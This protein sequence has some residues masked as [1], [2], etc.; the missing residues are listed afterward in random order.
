[1]IDVVVAGAGPGGLSAAL[2]LGRVGRHVLVLDGGPWRNV[3]SDTI[4]SFFTQDGATPA[5]LKASALA[6]LRRYP[7]VKIQHSFAN[8]AKGEPG[9]FEVAL[10]NGSRVQARGLLLATGVEDVLPDIPGLQERWGQSVV[11]CPYCHGWERIGLPLAVLA[12]DD[13]WAVPLAI[14]VRRF[15]DDV[16]LCTNGTVILTDE[17]RAQL[18]A[19][20]VAIRDEPIARLEGSRTSLE[21]MVFIN[22]DP[23][24]RAALF[25]H[26]PTRQRSDLAAE[27]G[28]RLLPNGAVE[29]NDMGQT[30]QPGI[31]A[32]GDMAQTPTNPFPAQQVAVAVGTGV[33]AAMVIDQELLFSN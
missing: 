2:C 3:S 26:P 19:G 5:E 28:C 14:N 8:S 17:Q 21:R 6:Q 31:Y 29:V 7:S 33:T 20:D 30:S 15:S 32:V 9:N 12:L 1:M 11:H 23:L 27:L 18:K 22:G 24:E 10:S 16:V 13:Q 25:C 4:H